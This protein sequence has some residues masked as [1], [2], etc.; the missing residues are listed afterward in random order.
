MFV[1]G[2]THRKCTRNLSF[3]SPFKLSGRKNEAF[4]TAFV[5]QE[6]ESGVIRAFDALQ[7]KS[8]QNSFHPLICLQRR[9]I[10]TTKLFHAVESDTR[11]NGIH[12]SFEFYRLG[13]SQRMLRIFFAVVQSFN[14]RCCSKQ[15][16]LS[17]YLQIS[18]ERFEFVRV[19]RAKA[20]E[21]Y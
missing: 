16:S 5:G 17:F 10:Y 8:Y 11:E 12:K 21:E 3:L 14:L 9:K 1:R 2:R 18:C 7:V 13:E 6:E 4:H 20:N 19:K 15:P